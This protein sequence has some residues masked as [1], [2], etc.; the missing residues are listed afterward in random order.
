MGL[1]EI[2]TQISGNAPASTYERALKQYKII[3]RV[4]YL[5]INLETEFRQPKVTPGSEQHQS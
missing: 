2:Y 3:L 5:I 4:R 1:A